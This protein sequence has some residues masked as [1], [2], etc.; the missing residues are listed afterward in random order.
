MS[1]NNEIKAAAILEFVDMM[2]CAFESGFTEKNNPTLSEVHGTAIYYVKD[3]Y[4]VDYKD[5]CEAWGERLAIDCGLKINKP[6]E[7]LK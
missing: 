7:Q 6:R 4:G 3:N 2:I 5:I 1:N